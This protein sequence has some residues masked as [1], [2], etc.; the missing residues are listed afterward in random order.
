LPN[1]S[2]LN[3]HYTPAALAQVYREFRL[4]LTNNGGSEED[5]RGQSRL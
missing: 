2:G 4:T 5:Q 1:P 3:A